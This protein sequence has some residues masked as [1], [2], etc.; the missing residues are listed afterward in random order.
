MGTETIQKIIPSQR[1]R[2]RWLLLLTTLATFAW[3][4][5]FFGFAV[6]GQAVSFVMWAE[7]E[8]WL[9]IAYGAS[10]SANK[11]SHAVMNNES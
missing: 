6:E 9:F 8:K 3:L 10:E 4:F 2:L 11:Y 1:T 7:F 5:S